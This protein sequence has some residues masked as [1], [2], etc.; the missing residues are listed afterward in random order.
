MII[1][2]FQWVLSLVLILLAIAFFTLLERK[3]LGYIHLRLGPNRVGPIGILQPIADALK[4]FLKGGYFL[5]YGRFYL[6]YFCPFWTVFLIFLLWVIYPFWANIFLIKI[7]FIVFFCIVRLEVY[8]LLLRGWVRGVKYSLLGSYRSSAQSISYEIIFIFFILI[9]LIFYSIY[10]IIEG[11][12]IL[13]LRNKFFY[14]LP[15]FFLWGFLLMAE[16]NRTPFDFSEGESELVSGFN[17]E[18]RRGLF[19]LI[20]IAEYGLILFFSMLST[21][22]LFSTHIF[23]IKVL[24][25]VFLYI[26]IRGSFP[27][28]RYDFLISISWL[29]LLPFCLMGFL[30]IFIIR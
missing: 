19:S 15:F 6:Y 17:T 9:F 4:L 30:L 10:R 11:I 7:S 24:F 25:F 29:N 16:A 27:R 22:L 12:K 23:N 20:F 1:G 2:L 21:L 14:F 18:Y 13:L 5:H 3:L 26:W 8:F 28:S